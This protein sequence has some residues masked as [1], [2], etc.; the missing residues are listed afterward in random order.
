VKAL[1]QG[2]PE[3]AAELFDASLRLNEN[4]AFAWGLSAVTHCYLG[5]PEEALGRLNNAWRL[6]PFDPLNFM[7]W[8]AAG[9]AEFLVADMTAP[10]HGSNGHCSRTPDSCQPPDIDDLPL[11][12]RTPAGGA[13]RSACLLALDPRFRISTFA[14]RYPLR[15]PGDLKRYIGGLRA[16]G[17]PE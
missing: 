1:L 11:A 10:S 9:L 15:R 17:L 2:R 3:R 7:S 14:S 8:S 5:S 13:R 16:A 6:S 4:S 12:R